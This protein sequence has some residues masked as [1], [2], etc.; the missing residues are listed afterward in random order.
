MYGFDAVI[1]DWQYRDRP[2]LLSVIGDRWSAQKILIGA[3][4]VSIPLAVYIHIRIHPLVSIALCVCLFMCLWEDQV[5]SGAREA[6]EPQASLKRWTLTFKLVFIHTHTHP[7][8][9]T[10]ERACRHSLNH[11]QHT[12]TYSL[13]LVFFTSPQGR[14]EAFKATMEPSV[15]QK[16]F[17]LGISQTEAVCLCVFEDGWVWVKEKKTKTWRKHNKCSYEARKGT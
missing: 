1:V 10:H 4:L 6:A 8:T 2:I 11:H 9:H 13:T 15:N 14:G 17:F 16:M 5:R 3:S 7:L 12:H